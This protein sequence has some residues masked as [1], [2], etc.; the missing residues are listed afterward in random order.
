MKEYEQIYNRLNIKFDYFLSESQTQPYIEKVNDMLQKSK[1]I[2]ERDG[3]LH[4]DLNEFDLGEP[5]V[6]RSN[7]SAVYLTRDIASVLEKAIVKPF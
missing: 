7:G 6:Q 3:A 5:V 4:A 2:F 1:F